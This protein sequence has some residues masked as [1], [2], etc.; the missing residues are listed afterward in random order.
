MIRACLF[1]TRCNVYVRMYVRIE[2]VHER[3]SE[4]E[5][6]ECVCLLPAATDAFFLEMNGSPAPAAAAFR[7]P[8]DRDGARHRML[9]RR[10]FFSARIARAYQEQGCHK[11][12]LLYY[13]LIHSRLD[14]D[15]V[16][17]GVRQVINNRRR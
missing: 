13:S 15:L 11:S 8:P 14:R 4:I 2:R 9:Q 17:V 6:S 16:G 5:P 12:W 1:A 3:S 7:S 10:H